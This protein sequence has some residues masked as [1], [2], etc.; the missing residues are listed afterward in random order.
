M[1]V[2]QRLPATP[3]CPST[4]TTLSLRSALSFNTPPEPPSLPPLLLPFL[5][6]PPLPPLLPPRLRDRVRRLP[7]RAVQHVVQ[8]GVVWRHCHVGSHALAGGGH[9]QQVEAAPAPKGCQHT[10]QLQN[11]TASTLKEG[12]RTDTTAMWHFRTAS[13]PGTVHTSHGSVP[14]Q[15]PQCNT[16]NCVGEHGRS[17]AGARHG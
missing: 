10:R 9:V 3:L 17:T 16:C 2:P 14:S 13:M 1:P 15:C 7:P 4:S 11:G 5:A 12:V 8:G 6:G